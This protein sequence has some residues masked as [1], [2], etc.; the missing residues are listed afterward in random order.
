MT[1]QTSDLRTIATRIASATDEV[2]DAT[3]D[4]LSD[5]LG[6]VFPE[7]THG[8]ESPEMAN[9]FSLAISTATR[10]FI[11]S[12]V[13]I[14][15]PPTLTWRND[16]GDDVVCSCG[17]EVHTDGFQPCDDQGAEVEP[18]RKSWLI[19]LVKCGRCLAIFHQPDGLRA[20][21]VLIGER[22]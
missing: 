19:S 7:A 11:E 5:T 2:T 13:R 8:D 4:A 6:R 22:L 3:R 10:D 20:G 15:V 17:N 9:A 16:H 1:T 12:W 18:L 21:S 14:N